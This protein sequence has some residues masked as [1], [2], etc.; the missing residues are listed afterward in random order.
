[1]KQKKIWDYTTY[2]NLFSSWWGYGGHNNNVLRIDTKVW[3]FLDLHLYIR[4]EFKYLS[5]YFKLQLK[6]GDDE[7][8]V[9]LEENN[10]NY[11]SF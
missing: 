9:F 5:K 4:I 10:N 8:V 2:I 11:F 6:N 3:A 1:M 7:V